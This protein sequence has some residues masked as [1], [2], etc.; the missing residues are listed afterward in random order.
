[1]AAAEE[2]PALCAQ[3]RLDSCEAFHY[4]SQSGVTRIEGVVDE[5]DFDEVCNA[6]DILNFEEANQMEIWK[7]VAAILHL[8]NVKFTENRNFDKDEAARIVNAD[9][10]SF[11]AGLIGITP[12]VLSRVLTQRILSVGKVV[13]PYK[14]RRRSRLYSNK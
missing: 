9:T 6:M 14:V 12:A 11:A 7:I 5:N 8:G 3:L 4:L 1:V 10:L 13:V 2:D